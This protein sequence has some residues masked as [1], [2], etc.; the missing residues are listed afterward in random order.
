MTPRASR[1]ALM[2]ASVP[3]E[4]KRIFSMKGIA[5]VMQRGQLDFEFRGGSRNW[6]PAALG[7]KSP[8]VTAGCAW[9]SSMAPQEQT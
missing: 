3:L 8:H 7:Q 1:N 4:T 5:R 6:F 9:P 2:V